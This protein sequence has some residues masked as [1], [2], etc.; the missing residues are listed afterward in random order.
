MAEQ[1]GTIISSASKAVIKLL[2][3][4]AGFVEGDIVM[5]SPPNAQAAAKVSIFLYQMQVNADLR[6][7]DMEEVGFDSLRKPPLPLDLSYLITPLSTDMETALGH[8]EAITR[9]FYDNSVLQHPLLSDYMVGTGNETIRIS[10][11]TLN[12]EDTNRLWSMFPNKAYM[13]SATYL[14][15]PVYVPSTIIVP[16]TRV[17]EK[18]TNMYQLE[19]AT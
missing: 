19:D 7:R 15:S 6:N 14:L 9:V 4:E 8:L 11:F 18:T 5:E 3:D 1:V 2:N 12:L 17:V 13:L 10:T 16:I